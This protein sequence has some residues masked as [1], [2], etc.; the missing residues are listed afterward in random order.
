[1]FFKRSVLALS[2]IAL[3]AV[4]SHAEVTYTLH[5]SANPTADEQD[6]YNRIT[7]HLRNRPE[8]DS[9]SQFP[10]AKSSNFQYTYLG[11]DMEEAAE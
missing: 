2:A 11:E 10:S 3:A 1:M 9:R 5:K 8:V 4:F 6:A 7:D